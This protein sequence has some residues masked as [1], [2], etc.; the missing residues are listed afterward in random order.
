MNDARLAESAVSI[1]VNMY[2]GILQG[3]PNLINILTE[4]KESSY[5]HDIVAKDIEFTQNAVTIAADDISA[6]HV[7]IK[8]Q[9][10]GIPFEKMPSSLLED[11]IKANGRHVFL[12]R[13]CDYERIIEAVQE[14]KA[15]LASKSQDVDLELEEEQ[16]LER[17]APENKTEDG[18]GEAP[19]EADEAD[20]LDEGQEEDQEADNPEP[21]EK[22]K[23]K[24]AR[25]AEPTHSSQEAPEASRREPD[26]EELIE[27]QYEQERERQRYDSQRKND[28]QGERESRQDQ[29]PTESSHW[30]SNKKTLR[31]SLPEPEPERGHRAERATSEAANR[32]KSLNLSTGQFEKG[33]STEQLREEE[34]WITQKGPTEPDVK[35]QNGSQTGSE[36]NNTRTERTDNSYSSVPNENSK[37]AADAHRDGRDATS[38]RTETRAQEERPKGGRDHPERSALASGNRHVNAHFGGRH[39][40]GIADSETKGGVTVLGTGHDVVQAKDRVSGNPQRA[41]SACLGHTRSRQAEV[42]SS[43]QKSSIREHDNASTHSNHYPESKRPQD[44]QGCAKRIASDTSNAANGIIRVQRI[45]A[46]HLPIDIQQMNFFH[47]GTK[48]AGDKGTS[49][50]IVGYE[51][52][53][54]NTMKRMDKGTAFRSKDTLSNTMKRMDKG[55]TFRRIDRTQDIIN[56]RRFYQVRDLLSPKNFRNAVSGTKR[57]VS[58]SVVGR[59]TEGGRAANEAVDY[60][61]PVAQF[62]K[63]RFLNGGAIEIARVTHCDMDVLTAAYAAKNNMSLNDAKSE[64]RVL[65]KLDANLIRNGGTGLNLAN[66]GAVMR[67]IAEAYELQGKPASFIG[68]L[69]DFDNNKF[70]EF[71]SHLNISDELREALLKTPVKDIDILKIDSLVKKYG[72]NLQDKQLLQMMRAGKIMEHYPGAGS[73]TALF[74]RYFTKMIKELGRSSD[75]GRALGSVTN[76]TR[77][78]YNTYRAGIRLLYTILRKFK[79]VDTNSIAAQVIADPGKAL[80]NMVLSKTKSGLSKGVARLGP[81][82]ARSVAKTKRIANHASSALKFLKNPLSPLRNILAKNALVRKIGGLASNLGA[83]IAVLAAKAGVV[84]GWIAVAIIVVI[85][86]IEIFATMPG[87]SSDDEGASNYMF[88]QDTEIMQEIITELTAKNEAFIGDINNAANHRGSYGTTAGLTADEN[89]GFYESG[90]YNIVFR[91]AYGNELEPSHVDLNNTKAI[92]AMASKFIPY[93]FNKPSENASDEEKKAYEDIKQH[94]KDYCYFLWAST[95]QIS[96]EEYHPGNSDGVEGA[97]DNSGLVTSLD[98]GIC[99]KDGTTI[100]LQDDFS[101]NIVRYNNSEWICDSCSDVPATGLGDYYDDLCTHGKDTNPHGGWRR[102]GNKREVY[103]CQD[104]HRHS[105]CD[106]DNCYTYTCEELGNAVPASHKHWEY[107]WVYDC[108]GHMG[109]VV[110]VTIGDLSRLPAFG[111]AGDVDYEA[112]GKY[113]TGD[114]IIGSDITGN[115]SAGNSAF[116]GAGYALTDEQIRRITALCIQEQGADLTAIAFEAS[117]IA[118]LTDRGGHGD[119]PWS[120]ANSGWFA[121]ESRKYL[122]QASIPASVNGTAVTDAMLSV[123]KNVLVNGNRAT[124]ATEHDYLGDIISVTNN[125]VPFDKNDRSKYISGVT[126]IKNS[127]GATYVFECF[128]SATSDPF[129]ML[130]Q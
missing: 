26:R 49:P 34:N 121:S 102:S 124:A 27:K 48:Y 33:R 61:S 50:N 90:A 65:R 105:G 24:A 92:L 7:E 87:S 3:I 6:R 15:E 89:V 111:A 82:N 120:V 25:K 123:V 56:V 13:E 127:M 47:N 10:K 88:V 32:D 101:K 5:Y 110:Y 14:I 114:G 22:K 77:N 103:N 130:T 115:V 31:G 51:D 99:D 68:M 108:G 28:D 75:A 30:E 84:L 72:R 11:H 18:H 122:T 58:Q 45:D 66:D 38:R 16:E 113:E 128:P 96:I 57:V 43:Q 62:T 71:V 21:E 35:R 78:V 107:E 59:D 17:E 94:Y 23:G 104:E 9:E 52:T 8:L 44:T 112:V 109:S 40:S 100:W 95:H 116:K 20:G 42:F 86:V 12:A 126:I 63:G 119:G 54:S 117:L 98:R 29:K 125:G 73:F 4:H 93:P 1:V 80:G 37:D 70:A 2:T 129:G 81:Q 60:I 36:Q 69:S 118:N 64:L 19:S 79:V 55:T 53:S 76:V 67:K 106:E 46:K 85:I 91:D 97:V 83:K 74:R 41:G 39:E